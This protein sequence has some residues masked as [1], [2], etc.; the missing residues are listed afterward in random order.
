V[1]SSRGLVEKIDVR[2]NQL[3]VELGEELPA[4]RQG[5]GEWSGN[6]R[7]ELREAPTDRRA[8]SSGD[9]GNG[10]RHRGVVLRL[11]EYRGAGNSVPVPDK[12]IYGSWRNAAP[13][14]LRRKN[15]LRDGCIEQF[16]GEC[17]VL[18][19]V[20]LHVSGGCCSDQHPR[21][22]TSHRIVL[23]EIRTCPG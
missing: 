3:V 8:R 6:L 23:V 17:P 12:G 5:A 18:H 11:R 14:R 16:V 15:L 4:K 2:Q 7:V 1:D 19:R 10:L 9:P 21:R 13:T 20:L 22:R